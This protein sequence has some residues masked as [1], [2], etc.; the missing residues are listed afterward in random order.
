MGWIRGGC[1]AAEERV[2]APS[3]SNTG[4]QQQV[5]D[6]EVEGNEVWRQSPDKHVTRCPGNKGIDKKMFKRKNTSGVK[7]FKNE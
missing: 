1:L 4:D 2:G 5:K 3:K 6:T 7:L